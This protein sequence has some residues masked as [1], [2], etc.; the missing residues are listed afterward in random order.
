MLKNEHAPQG[1]EREVVSVAEFASKFGVTPRH[2]YNLID[3]NE[4]ASVRIGGA[5]RIPISEIARLL[6]G[7]QG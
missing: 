5:V 2:I 6:E 4:V 7:G 3:R 1:A